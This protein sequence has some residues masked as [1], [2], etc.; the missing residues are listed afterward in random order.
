VPDGR[1]TKARRFQRQR[2]LSVWAPP[3]LK[4]EVKRI[5]AFERRPLSRV[6]AGLLRLGI[7]RYF[8]MADAKKLDPLRALMQDVFGEDDW[9]PGSETGKDLA[10][11]LGRKH[12]REFDAAVDEGL[13]AFASQSA[14]SEP[15]ALPVLDSS[16]ICLTSP[17]RRAQRLRV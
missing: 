3:A 15:F 10:L 6:C 1:P 17:S 11:E 9:I 7:E 12:A 16:L 2:L 13:R 14:N 8:E 4:R 5:A